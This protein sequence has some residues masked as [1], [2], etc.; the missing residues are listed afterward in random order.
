MDCIIVDDDK[1]SILA[2]SKCIEMTNHVKLK[3]TFTNGFEALKFLEG[4]KIDL[5]FLDVEMPELD[6]IE[7][8]KSLE[9]KPSVI[10][11]SSK[12]DYAFEGFKNDVDDYIQKPV[13]FHRFYRSIEKVLAKQ[14]N[15]TRGSK[16]EHIFVKSDS[17]LVRV[18]L[19]DIN[20]IEAMGDYVRIFTQNQKHMVLSTMKAFEEKLPSDQFLRVHKSF[21]VNLDKVNAIN[22]F[23]I[24]FENKL[25]PISKSH[26]PI[27]LEKVNLI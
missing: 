17:I 6:G 22:G 1:T 2:L 26:K 18:N 7:L 25:I 12:T 21:I 14:G 24:M 15:V 11:V 4:N 27:L 3:E 5:I 10:M 16:D 23:S 20:Y 9:N 19:K 8:L 13:E